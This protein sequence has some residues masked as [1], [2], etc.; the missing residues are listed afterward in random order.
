MKSSSEYRADID[1][2]RAIAV[3]S[4]FIYHLNPSWLPGGYLG[5]DVFFV[6][7]GYLITGIIV[8]ENLQ[9]T[10]S[11]SHFYARRIKRIFP[12]LFVVL[13]L[14]AVAAILVLTPET[15][16]NY[17]KSSRYAAAQLA[18]FFFA[19]DV[20]YF[21]E[22][23][24]DQPL[25][26]TWTLAV[27]EQFYLFW[28]LIIFLCFWFFSGKFSETIKKEGH[29]VATHYISFKVAIIFTALSLFS[30]SAGYYYAEVD[31]NIAFYMFYTRAWEF[32]FGGLLALNL[33][34]KAKTQLI[35]NLAGTLGFILLGYSFI[36]INQEYLGTSYLRIGI[37]LP[38]I[39]S[40]LI[41][42][43]TSKFSI[44]N[45][46]L[47]TAIPVSIGKIS[48]SLYLYHW[49][50]IIF[51]KSFSNQ[52]ELD[53]P[54]YLLII[55][56]SFFLSA[57]SYQFIE[58]PVRKSSISNKKTFIYGL[59]LIILFSVT[60]KFLEKSADSAWRVS[61]IASEKSASSYKQIIPKGCKTSYENNV[62][63]IYCNSY[64][65]ENTPIIALVG[66]SHV[67][68]FL[69]SLVFWSRSNGFAVLSMAAT[70]C[71]MLL[72][73]VIVKNSYE[74]KP[75]CQNALKFLKT[76]F[77]DNSNINVIIFAQR[78]DLL[79]DGKDYD[80]NQ[81]S[82]FFK[83]KDLN[84][85]SNQ[86]NYFKNQLSYTIEK[87]KESGK[88]PIIIKQIPLMWG[89]KACRWEPLIFKLLSIKRAC[90]FDMEFI[91]RWQSSSNQLIDNTA[92]THN[93]KT[94]DLTP[95][96]DSPIQDGRKIYLD[97]DHFNEYGIQFIT[98][99]FSREMDKVINNNTKH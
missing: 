47:A 19:R 62:Q 36:F 30:F 46:L 74:K 13:F 75:S 4:V 37:I 17:M 23:Y 52:N 26:H 60:Y 88:E 87:I 65:E 79:Y 54:A 28:P 14:S 33:L 38:V 32:G 70:A 27:E 64:A 18:N 63:L 55:A 91:Q 69:Q 40:V 45:K 43:S 72:G 80:T 34:P 16:V 24:S 77:I 7:S 42:Y 71:P 93:L 20:G 35:N 96:L 86:K 94:I 85:I 67:N 10:F 84:T 68:N 99:Y 9:H 82:I 50:I 95:Y 90:N 5:V 53:T 31:H 3:L 29:S 73:D 51:Y 41:M 2:L 59:L 76:K 1:G 6:I 21:D 83:D 44:W 8:R 15:Y 11:F 56:I 97:V 78:F 22:G 58:Q 81:R 49:P 25:L 12:A 66:D 61:S 89:L 92:T 57:L 39:G 98:P 48:Y